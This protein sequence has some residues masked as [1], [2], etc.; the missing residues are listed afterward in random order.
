M[1][2]GDII[3]VGEVENI[4]FSPKHPYTQGLMQAIPTEDRKE[5][6]GIP[7][8]VPELVE[9]PPGCRFHP[10]CPHVM[11]I[12]EKEK[13]PERDLGGGHLVACYLYEK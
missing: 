10:R 7:G 4:I 1:Y 6:E 3:E 8:T 9:P 13:P 5:L 11:E 2:A 12:C